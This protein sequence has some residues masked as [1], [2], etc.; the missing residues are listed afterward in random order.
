MPAG[1]PRPPVPT[2]VDRCGTGHRASIP[3]FPV[4]SVRTGSLQSHKPP[5]FHLAN[6]LVFF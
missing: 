2:I 3:S 6:S 4:S 1:G 5:H